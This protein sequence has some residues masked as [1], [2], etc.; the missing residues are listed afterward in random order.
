MR[1]GQDAVLTAPRP[2]H[3]SDDTLTNHARRLRSI[4]AS[5]L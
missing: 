5:E 2:T 4:L 3:L 1:A